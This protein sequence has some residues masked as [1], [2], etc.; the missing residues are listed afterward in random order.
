MAGYTGP[1]LVTLNLDNLVQYLTEKNIELEID[2]MV[3]AC[4]APW[5]KQLTE[6]MEKI[7]AQRKKD[8][9]LEQRVNLYNKFP[10]LFVCQSVCPVH[11]SM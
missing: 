1:K 11:I 8:E 6:E 9:K 2:E 5:T 3:Q 4:Q 7:E 10:C